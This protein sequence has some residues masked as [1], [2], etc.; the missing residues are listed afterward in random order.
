MASEFTDY[1][2]SSYEV[3]IVISTF[4]SKIYSVLRALPV[5]NADE[6]MSVWRRNSV[7]RWNLTWKICFGSPDP[8]MSTYIHILSV[9]INIHLFW[10]RVSWTSLSNNRVFMS[11]LAFSND[12]LNVKSCSYFWALHKNVGVW[13]V[14][15]EVVVNIILYSFV[16]KCTKY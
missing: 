3:M 14:F 2:P 4:F 7:C 12:I 13:R 8:Y 9:L 6:T 15:T 1:R 5:K 16:N 10:R 11:S